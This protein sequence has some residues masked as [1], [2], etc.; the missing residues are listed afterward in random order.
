MEKILISEFV[1]TELLLQNC[2]TLF[3][4]DFLQAL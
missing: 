1:N 3:V 2:V 4:K